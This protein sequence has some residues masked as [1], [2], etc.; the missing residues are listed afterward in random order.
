[1]VYVWLL[2]YEYTG[3]LSLNFGKP[4]MGCVRV[5]RNC[6]EFGGPIHLSVAINILKI[7]QISV[8][9]WFWPSGKGGTGI[10]TGIS[11]MN[12]LRY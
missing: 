12:L 7:C 8:I 4:Q 11:V 10:L 6:T 3:T 5:Q 2:A 1:M 9:I